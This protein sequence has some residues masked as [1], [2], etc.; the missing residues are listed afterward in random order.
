LLGIRLVSAGF[1]LAFQFKLD[2][3]GFHLN[4][5]TL[6]A[7]VSCMEFD[8]HVGVQDLVSAAKHRHLLDDVDT[9]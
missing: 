1:Q 5:Y 2:L 3:T 4:L 7:L 6:A 9:D 8:N